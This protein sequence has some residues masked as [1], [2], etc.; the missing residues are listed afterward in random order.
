MVHAAGAEASAGIGGMEGMRSKGSEMCKEGVVGRARD[1]T[2]GDDTQ[3]NG[4]S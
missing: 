3:D 1:E 4:G 2:K